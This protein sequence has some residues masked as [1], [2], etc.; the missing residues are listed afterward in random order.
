MRKL[1][2]N[3]KPDKMLN[4]AT[5]LRFITH[6][7]LGLHHMHRYYIVHRDLKPENLLIIKGV[8]KIADFGIARTFE[9]HTRCKTL[10]SG[11]L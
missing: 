4:E 10:E 6:V 8:I 3:I 11:S 7:C 9:N 5:I 2:T 1:I